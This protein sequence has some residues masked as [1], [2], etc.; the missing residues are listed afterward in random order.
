[1]FRTAKLPFTAM[2]PN[3]QAMA[4]VGAEPVDVSATATTTANV[5]Q[6]Y[7]VVA[8]DPNKAIPQHCASGSK[9]TNISV[10]E[11][12]TT[13]PVLVRALT[14]MERY[15]DMLEELPEIPTSSSSSGTGAKF[16][17]DTSSSSNGGVAKIIKTMGPT[18]KQA[19]ETMKPKQ[20]NL[21]HWLSYVMC[22]TSFRPKHMFHFRL[23]TMS[24]RT[25]AIKD[26]RMSL[27][28]PRRTLRRSRKERII[29][30]E[31]AIVSTAF[32]ENFYS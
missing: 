16:S 21:Q 29:A 13:S 7:Q 3:L 31:S 5:H 8:V 22:R 28:R 20:V 27:P 17:T 6:E 14:P 12:K 30:N 23:V 9:D 1:M 24:A 11:T 18:H 26:S 15:N 32:E 2:F 10:T 25:K 19:W 4:T